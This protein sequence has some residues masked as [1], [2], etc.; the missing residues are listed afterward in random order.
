MDLACIVLPP[1]S[2]IAS[3]AGADRVEI[4]IKTDYSKSGIPLEF[5]HSFVYSEEKHFCNYN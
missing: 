4:E 5:L 1:V 3:N 2:L